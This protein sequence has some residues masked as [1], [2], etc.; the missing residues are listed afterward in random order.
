MDREQKRLISELHVKYYDVMIQY[1][2]RKTGIPETARDAVQEVFLL[3]I[4]R[5]DELAE[6]PN[7][8]GWLFKALY[9]TIS[10]ELELAHNRE[11][12]SL[13]E[14]SHEIPE[15]NDDP[16]L[17]S[18][19]PDGL[20]P[21]DREI[22]IMRFERQMNCAEMAEMLGISH[23]ACRKRLSRAMTRLKKILKNEKRVSHFGL[24]NGYISRGVN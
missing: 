4:L 18:V 5:V 19:L 11:E 12:I 8:A 24:L 1:A 22:L 13:E 23:S 17:Q 10:R 3:A 7:P 9:Y 15:Q 21:Q 14:L 20:S 2:I 16:G 6:H